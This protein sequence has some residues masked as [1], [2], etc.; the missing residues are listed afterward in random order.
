MEN[1]IFVDGLCEQY[2]HM[3]ELFSD[4][5]WSHS[6][7]VTFFHFDDN[8]SYFVLRSRQAVDELL[9]PEL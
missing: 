9:F 1:S 2:V 5:T 8:L 4:L 6:T 7:N 3:H